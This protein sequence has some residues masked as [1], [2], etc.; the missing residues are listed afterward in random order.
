MWSNF[1][2]WVRFLF[3]LFD[4]M[5][6]L[7]ESHERLEARL[8]LLVEEQ[9]RIERTLQDVTHGLIHLRD[10]DQ[11]ERERLLLM[12]ENEL[13]KFERQLPPRNPQ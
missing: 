3:D 7:R 1:F 6:K 2:G 11:H 5:K 12:L 13:L 4:E 9:R 10:N 8:E